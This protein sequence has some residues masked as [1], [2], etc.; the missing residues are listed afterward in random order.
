MKTETLEAIGAAG[1]K[2]TIIGGSV[3]VAGKLSAADIAAYIG[4]AVAIIGL[5][6]TWFYKREANKRDYQRNPGAYIQRTK[7]TLEK[8]RRSPAWNNAWNV[9]KYTKSIGRN[10]NASKFR[11]TL[12]FYEE[13]YRRT[14]ATGVP[15]VVDHIIPLRGD[16]VHG[17]HEVGNLQ[18]LTSAENLAKG[19]KIL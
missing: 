15:H 13:A 1:N 10:R 16:P 12:P 2:A 14:Q 8:N 19:N 18:V 17:W 5:L 6:I 11:E 3:A 7:V 4:A 9:W